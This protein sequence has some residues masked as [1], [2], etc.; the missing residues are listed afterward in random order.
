MC[1]KKDAPRA[2][3]SSTNHSHA[4]TLSF[5]VLKL[6]SKP[7]RRRPACVCHSVDRCTPDV[8]DSTA[9]SF[10]F[11]GDTSVVSWK[12]GT[13]PSCPRSLVMEQSTGWSVVGPP[14]EAKS[15]TLSSAMGDAR[16]ASRCRTCLGS[17]TE[18]EH[19]SSSGSHFQTVP[20]IPCLY[21]TSTGPRH[22]R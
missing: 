11:H 17:E 7:A 2:L 1:G 5:R 3:P 20:H 19:C 21:V 6:S 9:L 4:P 8:P 16:P 13:Q 10:N 14:K 12:C 22:N 15:I 18:R